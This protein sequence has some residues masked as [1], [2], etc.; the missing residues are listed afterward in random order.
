MTGLI[1]F[2]SG[3]H[4]M[5]ECDM[6]LMLGTDFP[7]RQFYPSKRQ[8]RPDRPAGREPRPPLPWISAWSAMSARRSRHCCRGSQ[9]KTTGPPRHSPAHYQG[10][11]RARRARR[12]PG[13]AEA[14]PS[15]ISRRA[16]QRAGVGRCR[17]HLRCR[18][19]DGLGGALSEDERQAAADRIV[20]AWLD[21]E[22]AAAGDRRAGGIP[23][24]SGRSRC[25]GDGGFTM[26]M[27]DFSP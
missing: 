3:Y 25:R 9:A 17:L 24:P 15:A 11:R 16:D 5:I 26:L 6:L 4:A 7:Y 18:H 19:P 21:G 27:G 8:D 22:C 13:R 1:G 14:D 10:A 20:H 2:G 23:R 12:R